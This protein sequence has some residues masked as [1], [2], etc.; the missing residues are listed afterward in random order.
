MIPRYLYHYTS[1]EAL[2]AILRNRTIRFT[3][4]DR[5][6]D[7]FEGYNSILLDFRNNVFISSWTA[8][9][10]DALPMWKLYTDLKGLRLRMPIDLFNQSKNLEVVQNYSGDFQMRSVLGK[11]YI[12]KTKPASIKKN[13]E[14]D[15]TF[16]NVYGPTKVD[17]FSTKEQLED[18]IL[19]LK[20]QPT[21]DLFEI[22]IHLLGQ[23]K[24]DYWNFE[25]EYRFSVAYGNAR[26]MAGSMDV[27]KQSSEIMPVITEF[28]D[29]DFKESSLNNLE[30]LL[31][32]RSTESD[33]KT[34]EKLL[35]EIG[36]E[37]YSV[38]KSRIVIADK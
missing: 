19:K 12:I 8:E 31:G 32:P 9:E 15:M 6:N 35:K 13:F 26:I 29:I 21:F 11:P 30:I 2:I 25:K 7:P 17:Y 5:M 16:R 34:I 20:K 24:L 36:V 3:R 18:G 1:L 22:K 28:I 14:G 27:L 10:S 37:N 33:K 23:R 38:L 4:L